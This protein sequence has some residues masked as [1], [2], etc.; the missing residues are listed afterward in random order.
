MGLGGRIS[1]V[2]ETGRREERFGEEELW[3]FASFF[4][5][6]ILKRYNFGSL[7]FSGNVL[8]GAQTYSGL[9]GDGGSWTLQGLWGNAFRALV[10][11][12]PNAYPSPSRPNHINYG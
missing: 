12:H 4:A 7:N 2:R 1:A 9:H 5:S 3:S 11:L 8:L 6:T 10:S